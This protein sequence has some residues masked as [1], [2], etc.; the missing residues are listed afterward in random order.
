MTDLRQTKNRVNLHDYDY[1]LDVKSRVILSSIN[2]DEL[3]LLEELL[4]SSLEVP[5]GTLRERVPIRDDLFEKALAKLQLAGLLKEHQGLLIVDKERRKYF[6]TQIQR[7]DADFQPGV[8]FL[9]EIMRHIPIQVLPLW[10]QIPRSSTN[11]FESLVE[12][13]LHTPAIYERYLVEMVFDQEM[14]RE[15]VAMVYNAPH[16]EVDVQEIKQSYMLSD[17][18]FEE[19]ALFLELNFI[20]IQKF[21]QVGECWQGVLTPLLEWREYL[22]FCEKTSL[23]ESRIAT[24]PYFEAEE[25]IFTSDMAR[26]LGHGGLHIASYS[27]EWRLSQSIDFS[28]EESYINRLIQKLFLVGYAFEKQ[29]L[30]HAT[31]EGLLWAKEPPKIRALLLFRSPYNVPRESHT[32][33]LFTE[34]NLRE[35]EKC[36]APLSKLGWV[37][38]E[39][40]LEGIAAPINDHSP[41]RL[42]KVGKRWKYVIPNYSSEE[43]EFIRMLIE[44]WFFE[45][46]IIKKVQHQQRRYICLSDLGEEL[47]SA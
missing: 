27:G 23:R 33:E 6:D 1:K 40:F 37:D 16:L 4:F 7:F 29:G 11:I 17:E 42:E 19:I 46:G 22:S 21:R 47:F 32:L 9:H 45:C 36:L 14:H 13:Y 41:I 20:C 10:Y 44:E 3:Q 26:L 28:R 18:Q 2:S 30:L 15:I 5:M 39:L 12:K 25:Y 35:V 31:P 34:K 24:K 38:L 8:D 43:K